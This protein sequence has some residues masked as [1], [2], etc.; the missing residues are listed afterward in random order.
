M[1]E[2]VYVL[3]KDRES[4]MKQILFTLHEKYDKTICCNY[5]CITLLDKTY[6]INKYQRDCRQDDQIFI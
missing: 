5:R 3:I 1:M 2:E 4:G 6:K